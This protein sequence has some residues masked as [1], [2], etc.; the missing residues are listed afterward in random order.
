MWKLEVPEITGQFKELGVPISQSTFYA[1]DDAPSTNQIADNAGMYS[2]RRQKGYVEILDD[3]DSTYHNFAHEA[4]HA[5]FFENMSLGLKIRDLE[6]EVHQIERRLFGNQRDQKFQAKPSENV[7]DSM[8][9]DSE[10]NTYL[11]PEDD[12]MEYR[13]KRNQLN[14]IVEDN[15][16]I[17]EGY[18]V[19]MEEEIV[20]GIERE[21]PPIYEQ[22]YHEIAEARDET[23]L[24]SVITFLKE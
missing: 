20:G 5:S 4:G 3:T 19:L 2:P 17:I 7:N 10:K 14:Y 16:A 21:L 8:L 13:Q 12:L 9:V 1:V 23:D 6:K 15:L 22:G 11:V 24:D 18:A